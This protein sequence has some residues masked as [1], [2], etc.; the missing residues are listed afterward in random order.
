MRPFV[1][2]VIYVSA[3]LDT[4]IRR[5]FKRSGF[6]EEEYKQRMKSQIDSETKKKLSD[7]IIFNND[8]DNLN[9]QIL[10]IHNHFTYK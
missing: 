10:N 3:D 7:F 9:E 8:G 1:D 6:S 4:R 2:K 5:T